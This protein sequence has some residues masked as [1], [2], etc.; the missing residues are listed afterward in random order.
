MSHLVTF[1][2]MYFEYAKINTLAVGVMTLNIRICAAVCIIRD[3]SRR[4]WLLI[5][6][7]HVYISTRLLGVT[8]TL[9]L[10]ALKTSLS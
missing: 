7:P 6:L 4:R 8:F 1:P 5:F 3:L 10:A 9:V 2:H